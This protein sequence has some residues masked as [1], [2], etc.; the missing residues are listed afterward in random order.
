MGV[1]YK[2]EKIAD[3]L[4]DLKP[5]LLKHWE[6]LAN[7]KTDRPLDPDYVGYQTLNDLGILKMFTV[8]VDDVLVGYSIWL[9]TNHLHYKTW[10][11]AVADIYWLHPD[12]RKTGMS[13]DFFFHTEDWLKAQGVKSIT[14]QDKVNHSHSKFFNRIGYKPIE[15]VYEKVI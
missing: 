12:N 9:V 13:F 4:E 7:H 1:V 8:R 14:V 2:E 3:I 15:Q 10:K 6:E 5:L 11:Y